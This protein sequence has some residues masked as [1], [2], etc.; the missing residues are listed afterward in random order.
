MSFLLACP[1][2]GERSAYEFRFGG[3]VK[4]RPQQGDSEEAWFQYIYTKANEAGEQ[5]EWWFHRNGC[6]K[7]FQ[8]LRD[9]RTN[10]V[11]ATWNPE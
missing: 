5:E 7:W 1:E 4:S 6:R 3:E 11:L 10:T 8:A 2:C 9:T